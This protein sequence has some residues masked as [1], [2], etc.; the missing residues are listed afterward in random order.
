MAQHV[1]L[2][3]FRV[4]APAQL[5]PPG[6]VIIAAAGIV[7]G[8]HQVKAQLLQLMAERPEFNIPVAVDAGVRRPPVQVFL[9]KGRNHLFP[10]QLLIVD[11]IMRDAQ[12]FTHKCRIPHI[13]GTA[14]PGVPCRVIPQLKGHA[15]DIIPLPQQ[16]AGRNGAIHPAAHAHHD[17]LSH[18]RTSF[19]SFLC[20]PPA[21]KALRNSHDHIAQLFHPQ[22]Q[23]GDKI[24]DHRHQY[25][26]QQPHQ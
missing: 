23:A 21:L 6:G 2:V 9:R 11:N 4:D 3:L 25:R 18:R 14:A 10:E 13:V 7:A 24:N 26:R 16:Q 1:A 12:L 22:Q 15:G 8:R 5:P 17:L 20:R 19:L